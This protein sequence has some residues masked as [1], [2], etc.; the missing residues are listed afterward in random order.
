MLIGYISSFNHTQFTKME[1]TQVLD[2]DYAAGKEL[3]LTGQSIQ[4]IAETAKW[5][6][7]LSI[8][9]FIG[10]GFMV[11]MGLVMGTMMSSFGDIPGMGGM[12]AGFIS[13]FYIIFAF[14][15]L[16]P[17]LQLFKFSKLAKQAI[18][19]NDTPQMTTALGHMKSLFKFMGILTIIMLALYVLLFVGAA[20]FGVM[21]S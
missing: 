5:G 17:C 7:F 1:N 6:T 10:I 21:A 19:S 16:Y 4:F 13:M 12:G 8:I 2:N 11:L 18:A 3:G 20:L 14:L 9:G 15:Y